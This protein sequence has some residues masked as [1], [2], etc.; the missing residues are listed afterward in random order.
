MMGVRRGGSGL[1]ACRH[2]V[3]A[4]DGAATGLGLADLR[5]HGTGVLRS[6]LL[7]GSR[8][9]RVMVL[10]VLVPFVL[11]F[12]DFALHGILLP[13][14]FLF[15]SVPP[16]GLAWAGWIKLDQWHAQASRTV[17]QAGARLDARLTF[18]QGE[19]PEFK[20]DGGRLAA[21]R[22][23][24]STAVKTFRALL[25]ILVVLSLP[26]RGAFATE[27]L[28][29]GGN[30]PVGILQ[31]AQHAQQHASLVSGSH[32]H[33]GS[34]A[35]DH[36]HEDHA[37]TGHQCNFCSALGNVAGPTATLTVPAPL[38]GSVIFSRPD[39][40]PARIIA[41]RLERPPRAV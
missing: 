40:P 16:P 37:G 36:G 26:L 32:H 19:G 1:R 24:L 9:A 28:C 8:N 7:S 18:P 3:H 15:S 13:A 2:Q 41:E 25:L 11:H 21:P 6:S 31:V 30:E 20:V 4:A 17:R 38:P 23:T 27:R 29:S 34:V 5:V 10:E 22:A 12:S 33:H 39:V 35:A 14:G